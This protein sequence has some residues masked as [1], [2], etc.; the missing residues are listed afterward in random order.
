MRLSYRQQRQ[1]RLIDTA[2]RR[3]DP[4]M[5]AMFGIFTRLYT[6]QDLPGA[7]RLPDQPDGRGCFRRAAARIMAALTTAAVAAT[8]RRRAPAAAPAAHREP[9]RPRTDGPA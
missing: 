4:H 8:T 7:E 2:V 6:D 1:L 9:T 5:G 3:S